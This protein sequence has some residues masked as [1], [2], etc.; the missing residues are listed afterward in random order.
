MLKDK[1]HNKIN[2]HRASKSKKR[3]VDKVHPHRGGPDPQMTSQ[4]LANTEGPVFKP[5][6][7]PVYHATKIQIAQW[8]EHE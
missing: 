6:Y 7:D 8:F 1:S 3:E 4:P 5:V 2:D